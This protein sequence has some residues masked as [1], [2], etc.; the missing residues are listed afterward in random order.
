LGIFVRRVLMA[1]GLALILTA[2]GA[3][4]MVGSDSGASTAPARAAPDVAAAPTRL[5]QTSAGTVGY[6]EVGAGKPLL[7]ITGFSA[8]MD[9]WLPSFVDTLAVHHEVIVFDNAGVGQTAPVAPSS[10]TAM[11]DQTSD[12]ISALHLHHPAVLGW[13]MG[14][15]IAQALAVDHPAQV[16]RLILAATQAGTGKAL[17]VPAAAAAQLASANPAATL[18]V[19]FPPGQNVAEGAYVRGIRQY[20]GFY[21]ASAAIRASQNVA[22][23][24]WLAGQDAPGRQVGKLRVPTLVADGTLDQLDPTANDRLLA[25]TVPHA[26]LVL[27]PGAGHAFLFQ[28]A[29]RFLPVLEAFIG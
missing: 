26:K 3:A 29:S 13:S 11:A 25:A 20:T 6:R 16:G 2:R 9:D 17:P 15:M 14:G 21:Q 5:V 18:S 27:Y 4:A 23:Q 12:L 7:L 22:I 24:H 10:I 8:S 28:D 19:L 1:S